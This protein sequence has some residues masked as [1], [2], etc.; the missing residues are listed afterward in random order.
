[1]ALLLRSSDDAGKGSM[2]VGWEE[3]ERLVCDAVEKILLLLA[4]RKFGFSRERRIPSE[5]NPD[6]KVGVFH[7]CHKLMDTSGRGV[8]SIVSESSV[9]TTV[10]QSNKQC[11]YAFTLTI[12]FSHFY[13]RVVATAGPGASLPS[14]LFTVINP[15][16]F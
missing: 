16:G 4:K 13:Y 10:I 1:M 2:T 14:V 9:A 5:S 11:S 8:G 12:T 6:S 3:E 7:F 15:N